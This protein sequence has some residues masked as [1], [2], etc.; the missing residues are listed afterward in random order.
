[1]VRTWPRSVAW[2]VILVIGFVGAAVAPPVSAQDSSA[3]NEAAQAPK[4]VDPSD[5][6]ELTV[7]PPPEL[8]GEEVAE[9]PVDSEG[10][11]VLHRSCPARRWPTRTASE[12]TA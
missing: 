9:W 5:P 8:P 12:A 1:V 11:P 4:A 7:P 10:N 6:C 2:V 3:V